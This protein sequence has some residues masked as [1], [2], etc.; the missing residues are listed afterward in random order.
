MAEQI[1]IDADVSGVL[2]AVDKL[3]TAAQGLHK[4]LGGADISVRTD[5]AQKSLSSLTA[6]AEAARKALQAAGSAFDLDASDQA[7]AVDELRA[8]LE[9]IAK[10]AVGGIDL[11]VDTSGAR[12]QIES[13]RRELQQRAGSVGSGAGGAG[14]ASMDAERRRALREEREE[15]NRRRRTEQGQGR[16]GAGGARCAT[17]AGSGPGQWPGTWWR[18]SAARVF[19]CTPGQAAAL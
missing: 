17:T 10:L 12:A 16:P 8:A 4:T 18:W 7:Q 3:K 6:T 14:G 19:F 9:D 1:K 2:G 15:R 11:R 5:Q 13:L